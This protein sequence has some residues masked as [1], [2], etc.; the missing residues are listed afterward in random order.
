[1]LEALKAKLGLTKPT[2]HVPDEPPYEH[3]DREIYKEYNDYR[4]EGAQK[5]FCYVPFNNMSFSFSGRTLACSYN[6]KVELGRYPQNSIRD[7]WFGEAG[8]RLRDHME[9]NDLGEGCKHCKYFFENRKFSGLKPLVFDKYADYKRDQYPQVLEFE[10]SN[11]CNLECVMCNGFVSSSI[12]K[13]RDKLPAIKAPYDDA[14]VDQLDEFIPHIKEAKFYGGE[15]FLIPIYYKI[16]DKM[17]AVNPDIKYFVITNGTVLSDRMKDVINRG[18]FDLAVSMDAIDKFT[19][20]SIRLNTEQAQVLETIDYLREYCKERGKN[21]TVSYTCMR[22]N[23]QEFPKMVEFANARDIHLYISY[24]KTPPHYALWNLPAD[25]L[26]EI[27][28]QLAPQEANMPTGDWLREHNKRCFTD[29]LRYLQNCEE[30]N[31]E[32]EEANAKNGIETQHVLGSDVAKKAKPEG[33]QPLQLSD[34]AFDG[35]EDPRQALRDNITNHISGST[36]FNEEQQKEKSEQLINKFLKVLDSVQGEVDE[37]TVLSIV[38]Q[39]KTQEVI[40]SI[41]AMTEDHLREEIRKIGA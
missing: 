20:E 5:L 21:L 40:E 37:K 41:E 17:L 18:D 31:R 23:W 22:E 35:M 27:R 2:D 9:H 16:W 6:Q 26:K 34:E 25:R 7:M 4:P 36:Y 29:F 24:L 33:K 12:R 1:M 10:L 3:I 28:E 11:V 30:K 13:N 39:A 8:E 38:L 15:P 19:L 32:E 14:F